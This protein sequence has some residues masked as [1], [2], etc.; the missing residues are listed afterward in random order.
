MQPADVAAEIEWAKARMINPGAYAGA[1]DDAG[2]R[3]P[4]TPTIVASIY[5]RYERLKRERALI[6]FDDVLIQCA[7]AMPRRP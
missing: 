6:D 3:P 5:E 1:C 2:R 7:R 4:L